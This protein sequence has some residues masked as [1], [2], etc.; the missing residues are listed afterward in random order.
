MKTG[1]QVNIT[2]YPSQVLDL[3]VAKYSHCSMSMS[4]TL[5]VYTI[6]VMSMWANRVRKLQIL[7]IY[8]RCQNEN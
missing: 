3:Y 8:T 2:L 4:I 6:K 1:L 5:N 7:F